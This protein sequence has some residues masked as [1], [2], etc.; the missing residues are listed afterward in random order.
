MPFSPVIAGAEDSA[1]IWLHIAN[2]AMLAQLPPARQRGPR[3]RLLPA[4][5][6]NR[7]GDRQLVPDTTARRPV[8]LV[9]RLGAP[10]GQLLDAVNVPPG[11]PAV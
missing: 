10:S 1:E 3:R 7:F 4:A 2:P 8:A 11:L 6:V 5:G 9:D